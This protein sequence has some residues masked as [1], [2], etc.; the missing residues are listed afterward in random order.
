MACCLYAANSVAVRLRVTSGHGGD[1][2]L[3]RSRCGRTIAFWWDVEA[4]KGKGSDRTE[5]RKFKMT[6]PDLDPSRRRPLAPQGHVAGD[7]V[8]QGVAV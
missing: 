8:F 4:R 3:Q 6:A 2:G 1:G 7:V 5:M